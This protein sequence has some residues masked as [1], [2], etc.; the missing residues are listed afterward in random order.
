MSMIGKKVEEF[1][2]QAYRNGE[3]IEV[4]EKNMIG[5]W[6][7]LCLYPA[8]FTFVWPPVLWDLQNQ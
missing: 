4:S 2:A 8:D 1:T 3:F 5:N 6:S 7:I